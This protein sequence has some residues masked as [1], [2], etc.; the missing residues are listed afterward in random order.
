[1]N[2]RKNNQARQIQRNSLFILLLLFC[3]SF[4]VA[5]AGLPVC[6]SSKYL[7]PV[8]DKPKQYFGGHSETVEDMRVKVLGGFARVNRTWDSSLG[9]WVINQR[10]APLTVSQNQSDCL[11]DIKLP[12]ELYRNNDLF[13]GSNGKYTNT[14]DPKQTITL[15][16]DAG[17]YTFRWQ[18][19]S[20]D[21]IDY[22]LVAGGTEEN[23][24]QGTRITVYGDRNNVQVSI[25]YDAEG[26]LSGVFDHHNKQ[27][28]WYEY[29]NNEL[30][31]IRDYTNRR[32]EYQGAAGKYTKVIDVRGNPW[33]YTYETN[34]LKTKTDPLGRIITITNTGTTASQLDQDG[35]GSTF[36]YEYDKNKRE[37]YKQERTAAGKV[38]ETWSD[39][40]GDM[41]RKDISG[42]TVYTLVKDGN[43]RIEAD[44]SG[45]KTIKEL[46]QWDNVIKVTYPDGSTTSKVY[47]PSSSRV[48]QQTNENGVVTKYE[49]DA[50]GNLITKTEAF[51]LPEQ[52][53]TRYGYTAFGNLESITYVGDA[54][55]AEA[56]ISMTYDDFGNVATRTDAEEHQTKF[57]EYDAL[58]NPLR[59]EDA[60][61]K[62]WLSTYDE[63]GNLMSRKTPLAHMVEYAYD[64]VNNLINATD[65]KEHVTQYRY[66]NKKRLIEIILP[67]T[68]SQKMD[69][70]A[71]GNLL[72]RTDPAGNSQYYTYDLSGRPRTATDGNGNVIELTYLS[73]AVNGSGQV[74]TI[75]FPTFTRK[76]SYD[77]RG[78]QIKQTNHISADKQLETRWEYD[79]LGNQ[80]VII[81]AKQ[82]RLKYSY[83]ALNRLVKSVDPL[84]GE[85]KYE[86]DNRDNLISLTDPNNHTTS[87]Q[88]D[89]NDN[90]TQEKR[91]MGEQIQYGYNPIGNLST[92]TDAKNQLTRYFYDDDLRNTNIRY[93]IDPSA[94]TAEKEVVFG[95]DESANLI[96]YNDGVTSASYT[97]N[98]LN[99]K[100]SETINYGGFTKT[101]S[102][103]YK[104]NGQ[105]ESF[106]GPDSV[107]V[108][109]GYD[110]SNLLNSMQLQ[111]G[112]LTVNSFNWVAP[113]KITLPGG[114]TQEYGY[115]L[116]LRTKAITIK[117]PATNVL[118]DRRY[119]YDDVGNMDTKDTEHG[120]YDFDYDELDRLTE[121]DNPSLSNEVY[122]YDDSSNRLADSRVTGTWVYNQNNQLTEIG[123]HTS[124]I[125]DSNGS[126]TQKTKGGDVTEYRYNLENRLAEV[127][128]NGDSVASYYYDP[129]GRRLWKDVGGQR[130]Y[131]LYADEGLIA[132]FE[133]SGA[134]VRQY[135][136]KPDSSWGTDPVYMYVGGV[137]YYYQNNYL[138]VPQKLV[139]ASG[140]VVWSST[141]QAF[142][143]VQVEIS[144][145][146]EN[147]LRFPGQYFDQETGLHYNYYRFY[148]PSVGRYITSDPIGLLGGVNTYSYGDQN[149]LI[150][151]DVFGLL[152]SLCY[153]YANFIIPDED[154][155]QWTKT[156]D[157]GKGVFIETNG[158][159]A[160]PT[161]Q[162][163]L[164]NFSLNWIMWVVSYHRDLLLETKKIRDIEVIKQICTH[165]FN[166]ECN[167]TNSTTNKVE[168]KIPGPWEIVHENKVIFT[169]EIYHN[170]L[171][172][173]FDSNNTPELP[174]YTPPPGSGN[175]GYNGQG[176]S[177]NWGR[178]KRSF[179]RRILVR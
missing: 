2:N 38:T 9:Q 72:K 101:Y 58:G 112:A 102:Y 162:K 30:S 107:T 148:D 125:Y 88:Y 59:I 5:L 119:S 151:T 168:T 52:R 109:Y 159:G 129:F 98:S 82:R 12:T 73:G 45:N 17:V 93:F 94:E 157:L 57:L 81:D 153:T 177:G 121:A 144:S 63:A 105:K 11:G 42:R 68:A 19:R 124:F 118:M 36:S 33:N 21:W 4:Q 100:L 150:M 145:S 64:E 53:I 24:Y 8:T 25:R 139:S 115:D 120:L 131:F 90:K 84:N 104:S 171:F 133:Q 130:T 92:V 172:K 51:E 34:K 29:K 99:Q 97:H 178:G 136:Y 126:L 1:M 132:E 43:K 6:N 80:V 69:Y 167:T 135:G 31:A 143:E 166:G 169:G 23:L 161:N 176:N 127:T 16:E 165:H 142:G 78:R 20:G 179:L 79:S 174:P 128:L 149:P 62:I 61:G 76:L 77:R 83:D 91:P 160:G 22:E 47:D 37:Y 85:T 114:I 156:E 70:D 155:K 15:K 158:G 75:V 164:F 35:V 74:G 170:K 117:D 140:K 65:S 13:K 147:P 49:Y 113:N 95:F 14:T 138:G 60:R 44:E 86:Y 40:E 137:Y 55:T 41:I 26:R 175:Q 18:N 134:A 154:V 123:S 110:Q 67:N 3:T 108:E 10:W 50:G 46:D 163:P 56:V 89:R 87:Y 71:D 32:V 106:T 103:T 116:L 152:S 111:S 28:L 7:L 96:S 146:V 48:L 141:Y 173:I 122:S 27:I 66:D 39:Y 54:K